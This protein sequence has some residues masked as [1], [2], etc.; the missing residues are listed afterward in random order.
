MSRPLT[1]PA[2]APGL[3]TT[4]ADRVY[5][6]LRSQIGSGELEPGDKVTERG[7]AERL[8]VSP[9]PVREA[10]RRLELDGLVERIGPRTTVVA[11]IEEDAA[12]DLAEVEVALRGLAA[13]FAARHAQDA[14]LEEL[15]RLLDEADDLVILIRERHRSGTSVTRHA[16]RLLDVIGRFNELVNSAAHNPVLVRLLEQ[17]RSVTPSRQREITRAHLLAG[18]EFGA[19]RYAEHRDL[20]IALRDRDAAEAERIVTAH[21]ARGLLDLRREL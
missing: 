19:D 11:R 16:D 12:H 6:A 14:E 17:S 10:I 3:P 20:V 21:A 18:D 7:L 8:G 4:V 13:R 1:L 15:D 2:P 9:T 5:H